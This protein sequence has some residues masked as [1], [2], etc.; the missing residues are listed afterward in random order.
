MK[1]NK[2]LSLYNQNNTEYNSINLITPYKNN[3]EKTY[4]LSERN[5]N[6]YQITEKK[7]KIPFTYNRNTITYVNKNN[8]PDINLNLDNPPQFNQQTENITKNIPYKKAKINM[9]FNNN[10]NE[11]LTFVNGNYSM[12]E[13]NFDIN[14]LTL[15]QTLNLDNSNIQNSFVYNSPKSQSLAYKKKKFITYNTNNINKNIYNGN[16]NQIIH[17]RKNNNSLNKERESE[18]YTINVKN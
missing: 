16:K 1:E 5:S 9:N 13:E 17:F 3:I 7:S 12:L 10:N 2:N 6:P 18:I 8:F 4:N 14:D 11:Y 15:N